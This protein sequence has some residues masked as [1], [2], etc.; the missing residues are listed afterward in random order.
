MPF[1]SNVAPGRRVELHVEGYRTTS[2]DGD[3]FR[4][5]YS[6][7]GGTSWNPVTLSLPLFDENRDRVGPLPASLSGSVVLRVVDTDRTPGH[8][9]LDTVTLD[10]PWIRS[11]N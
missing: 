7:N 5:D 10:Q 9:S 3:D 11:V 6:T 4:F 1:I 2:I 8:K